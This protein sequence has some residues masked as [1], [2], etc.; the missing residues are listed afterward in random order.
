MRTD[1]YEVIPEQI[2]VLID[3]I[4]QARLVAAP[5]YSEGYYDGLRMALDILWQ[6]LD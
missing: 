1:P 2:D 3:E 5:G 4:E 6:N